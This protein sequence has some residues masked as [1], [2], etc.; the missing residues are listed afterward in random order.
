VIDKTYCELRLVINM[1]S[2]SLLEALFSQ[3]QVV[4]EATGTLWRKKEV[5]MQV[6]SAW[7]KPQMT[8]AQPLDLWPN[9]PQVFPVLA[10]LSSPDF[11]FFQLS[12]RYHS[13]ERLSP[14]GSKFLLLHH[15]VLG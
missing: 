4:K 1:P 5:T 6:S 13:A 12:P 7:L 14:Q 9:T 15:C 10:I 8:A 11:K 3:Y 2:T